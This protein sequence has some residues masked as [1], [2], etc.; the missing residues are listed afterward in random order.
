[1]K[2]ITHEIALRDRQYLWEY[3]PGADMTGAYEDQHD[4][5]ELLKSPTKATAARLLRRQIEYWFDRGTDDGGKALVKELLRSDPEV[6]L[7][8]ERHIGFLDDDDDEEDQDA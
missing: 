5:E 4:L 6:Q 3:G 7:I 1:M 2:K 8:Y